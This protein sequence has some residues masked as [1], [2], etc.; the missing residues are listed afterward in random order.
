M[1]HESEHVY[2]TLDA[3]QT[4]LSSQGEHSTEDDERKM[5]SQTQQHQLHLPPQQQQHQPHQHCQE[6]HQVS[7]LRQGDQ[8][9]QGA[10]DQ[11]DVPGVQD[12]QQAAG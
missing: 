4:I 7:L 2:L 6:Q 11:H 1:T 9:H 5:Q 8:R 3:L 10:G 12:Q